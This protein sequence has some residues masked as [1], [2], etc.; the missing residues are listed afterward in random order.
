MLLGFLLLGLLL[1]V[2][3]DKVFELVNHFLEE[4]HAYVEVAIGLE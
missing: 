4:R 2:I 3:A 1:V